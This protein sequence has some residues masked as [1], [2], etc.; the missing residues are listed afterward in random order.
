MAQAYII[1]DKNSGLTI[2]VTD[3]MVVIHYTNDDLKDKNINELYS[4]EPLTSMAAIV[5]ELVPLFRGVDVDDLVGKY[6]QILDEKVNPHGKFSL[7]EEKA[8]FDEVA[9]ANTIARM[10]N[11]G[12]SVNTVD[13]CLSFEI[14]AE[15]IAQRS[16]SLDPAESILEYLEYAPARLDPSKFK[17]SALETGQIG[18]L[19]PWG[20]PKAK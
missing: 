1:G 17:I 15:T 12:N 18:P 2:V 3:P 19:D 5:R 6:G 14:Q 13:F 7:G 11:G 9:N 4:S 16:R 10:I 20:K 8:V